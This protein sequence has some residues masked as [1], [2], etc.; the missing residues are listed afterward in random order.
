VREA[1]RVQ[2]DGVD[3]RVARLDQD[4]E[5]IEASIAAGIGREGIRG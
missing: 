4:S 1:Q 5:S 3:V 2:T